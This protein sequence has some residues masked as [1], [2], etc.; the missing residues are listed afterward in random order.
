MR[1]LL[2]LML[3]LWA[4]AAL[5]QGFALHDLTRL[6]EASRTALGP[7]AAAQAAPLHLGVNCSSCRGAPTIELQLGRLTDGTEERVRSGRTSLGALE[8]LCVRRNPDCRLSALPA[9]PAIGWL[10][11]YALERGAGATAVI[12]RGGDLLTIEARAAD[13]GAAEDS[14]RRLTEAVLPRIVG[15]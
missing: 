9:G 6:A 11:V 4:Q 12:L 5:T 2:I 10:S 15:P 3:S 7:E 8:T 14:V 1:G 13:R